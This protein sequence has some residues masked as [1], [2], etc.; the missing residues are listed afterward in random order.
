MLV[1]VLNIGRN[2]GYL[3]L[4][5]TRDWISGIGDAPINKKYTVKVSDFYINLDFIVSFTKL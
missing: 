2:Y 1:I 3:R 4:A 5:T